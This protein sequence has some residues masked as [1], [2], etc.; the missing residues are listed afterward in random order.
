M[1]DCPGTPDS[2]VIQFYRKNC[3][4]MTDCPG[5][6]KL[7]EKKCADTTDCPGTP[8]SPLHIHSYNGYIH[9]APDVTALAF[10]CL[11]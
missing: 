1:T 3:A 11:F 10:V 6:K 4:D 8:D 7:K 2:L 5:R 9:L